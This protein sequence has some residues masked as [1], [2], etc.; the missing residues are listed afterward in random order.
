MFGIATSAFL[1]DA[2]IAAAHDLAAAPAPD[3]HRLRALLDV[4]A[5][6]GVRLD[7]LPPRP[8]VPREG[9]GR[10]AEVIR[11]NTP[12]PVE[13]G[14]ALRRLHVHL[15]TAGAEAARETMALV[16]GTSLVDLG[17]GAGA[18]TQAFLD[19]DP[20]R[21]ATLVDVP[22]I[23]ELARERLDASRV[24]FVASDIVEAALGA[25]D[26]ALLANVLH[27]HGPAMCARL[28]RIAARSVERGGCVVLKDLRVDDGRMGPL[29]GLL[30]ALNMALYTDEGSVYETA[31]LGAWLVEAG[32]VDVAEHR[33]AS[34]PNAIVVIG[35]RP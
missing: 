10:I 7:A 14:E 19:G 17:G 24:A 15:A 2:V 12:L 16:R 21:H 8:D 33:L 31:Q 25:H 30:F 20:A 27:L 1:R 35:R 18:Y 9:W 23:I 28:V 22:D 34:S 32:L 5:A 13:R 26:I 6:Y 11:S 4:L 3:G 29:E